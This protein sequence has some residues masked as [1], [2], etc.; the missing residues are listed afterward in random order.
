M[1]SRRY[2]FLFSL[3][4]VLAAGAASSSAQSSGTPPAPVPQLSS[5]SAPRL[6]FEASEEAPLVPLDVR[7]TPMLHQRLALNLDS[8]TVKDALAVIAQRSG[9]KLWY[10]D[11]V[12]PVGRIVHLRADEITL[13]AALTDVLVDANVDVVFRPDGAATLV[14]RQS[15]PSA[16]RPAEVGPIAGTII[17]TR[18]EPIAGAQ[19]AVIGSTRR[20]ETNAAGRFRFS[21][22]DG[23]IVTLEVTRIGYRRVT[24]PASVGDTAVRITLSESAI[25]LDAMVVTG[26]AGAEAKR[27]VGNAVASISANDIM[28][29]AP[30][31]SGVGDLINGRV[32]GVVVTPGTGIDGGGP[33][34]AIRGRSTISLGQSSQPLVYIDGVRTNNDVAQGTV[35]GSSGA[36]VSRIGDLN[37]EEIESIEIIR[38]PAAS[39]LYGTEASNGVIQI[40]TKKGRT[41]DQNTTNLSIREG[42]SW[43]MN[44]A[45]RIP[46]NFGL[47]ANGNVI[48][49][50]LVGQ[51]ARAG[52]PIF[53]TGQLQGFSGDVS[54]G[55]GPIKYYMS[56]GYDRNEG[57]DPT[58]VFGRLS[59]RANLAIAPSSTLDIS[60]NIGM[61]YGRRDLP[62]DRGLSPMFALLFANPSLRNG[63]TR[64]FDIAP[65][66]AWRSAYH[67]F[68]NNDRYITGLQVNHHPLSWL[69][70]RLTL[71]LD[72]DTEDNEV[73]IPLMPD[74][75]KQF[76]SAPDIL[77]RKIVN[78]QTRNITTVDYGATASAPVGRG[79][80][81]ASS[82]GAQYYNNY[83]QSQYSE[84]QGFPVSSIELVSGAATTFGGD[85]IIQNTTLGFYV[86]EQMALHDRLFLTGAIRSDNNSSFGSNVKLVTYPKISGSWVINE[87]PFWKIKVVNALKLRAAYGESGLQPQVFT[88]LQTYL[89]T[90][91]AN[92]A[93]V[94][95]STIGNPNLRPERGGELEAGFEAGMFDSRIGID[96][97]YYNKLTRDMILTRSVAPSTGFP[98]NQIFNAGKVRNTGAE[99][100][101][102]ATPVERRSL[103][104]TVSL[105]GSTNRSKLLLLDPSNPNLTTSSTT[106]SFRQTVGYPIASRWSRRIVSAT[107]NPVTKKAENVMCDGGRGAAPLPC[108]QAPFMYLGGPIP[109]YEG[110][111][112]NTVSLGQHFTFHVLV[113]FK[114]DYVKFDQDSQGRCVVFRVCEVN[115]SPEKFDPITVAYAQATDNSI[116][117]R[118][119]PDASFAKLREVSLNYVVPT[120]LARRIGGGHAATIS[121]AARNLYTWAPHY[122]SLDP[123]SE[124]M[125][126]ALNGN[127]YEQT[128]IPQLVSITTTVR[129]TW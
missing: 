31:I 90:A 74:S 124:D 40:V 68:S 110:G 56:A 50:D 86:Q 7:R 95:P 15:L 114:T 94:T 79:W 127:Y 22:V 27:S 48:E 88:A 36:F 29:T 20:T 53:R 47:D 55:Q 60:A 13:A 61:I 32:A 6:L 28:A 97:T 105:S 12:I 92:G 89:P 125:S 84:G 18:S 4:L 37:P 8:V 46:H 126:A 54:G 116:G 11:D 107:Y 65:P 100:L 63:P 85:G 109:R 2:H 121:L 34:I 83:T 44:L 77:G 33:L 30:I 108:S 93:A 59:S 35:I 49:Q 64:G 24:Q 42:A 57:I 113:D 21:Q 17:G 73:V 87:E 75:I 78:R 123:E 120:N 45:G 115:V 5:Q 1:H 76:F 91:G 71:G 118:W 25:T 23:H 26:T 98:Q 128:T 66:E 80:S 19:V 51:E 38:G 70:Q 3:V 111:L 10:V 14:R 58:N 67:T 117:A 106:S 103:R 43:F 41:A 62:L 112:T 104:W 9:L 101:L 81:S 102:N 52:R 72:H 96:F 39:T 99:L 16:P 129:I 82:V 122:T 119:Y 69:T